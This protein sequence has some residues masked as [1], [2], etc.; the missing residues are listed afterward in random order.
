M[1]LRQLEVF[2]RLF[3]VTRHV[4]DRHLA[5]RGGGGGFALKFRLGE[6]GVDDFLR[7][8]GLKEGGG[9]GAGDT[10]ELC[11]REW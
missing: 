1:L 11:E 5:G 8:A 2:P 7:E 9:S 10:L 3:R 6:G 4:E